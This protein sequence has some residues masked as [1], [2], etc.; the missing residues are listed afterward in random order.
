MVKV[1]I[2]SWQISLDYKVPTN[3]KQWVIKYNSHQELKDYNPIPEAYMTKRKKT[4]L[5][6]R[7][8]IVEYCKN[9][10]WNYKETALKFDCGYAQVYN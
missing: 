2:I 5:E 1:H 10:E 4:T 8:Q 9:H 7:K 6:E 3:L